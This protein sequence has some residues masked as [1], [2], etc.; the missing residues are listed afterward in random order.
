M[1]KSLFGELTS[2]RESN[3]SRSEDKL[4]H[5]DFAAT[6]LM[7]TKSTEVTPAGRM[8]DR[9][10][11][12]LVV[13][14]SPAQ[15]IR[16]HFASTRADLESASRMITL[17][18][19]SHAWAGWVIK[20]LS[21]AGG[22][23]IERL[24]LREAT[25]LRTLATIERT[26]LVRRHDDSLKIM[27]ADVRAPGRENS[28]IPVALMERSQLTT[29]IM[30]TLG[31]HA[32]DA[33]L[34]SVYEAVTLP[35]W[36]CPNI[37][38]LLPPETDWIVEKMTAMKW[39]PKVRVKHRSETL[40]SAS[41]VWNTVLEHWS[42]VKDWALAASNDP[43]LLGLSDF[44]I[45]VADLQ[46]SPKEAVDSSFSLLQPFD[47]FG[48]IGSPSELIPA[49]DTVSRA[50]G[51]ASSEASH[52]SADVVRIRYALLSMR[53]LEGMLACAV[54]DVTNNKVLAYESPAGIALDMDQAAAHATRLLRSHRQAA[55]GLGLSP[56]INEVTARAG[57]RQV[58]LRPVPR[59][60]RF[61]LLVLLD[62]S[63]A[64]TDA[65]R[66]HLSETEKLL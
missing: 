9:H 47:P 7:E 46:A 48:S 62:R 6:T 11:Q 28:E 5:S 12:E 18:D 44:P 31:S 63:L 58:I 38:F 14:G 34:A 36:R 51:Q 40:L 60:P 13:V 20:A 56:G 59:Q 53:T 23:P 32:V 66:R 55:T 25:T 16:Q 22:L 15:A 54:V 33:L 37:L 49:S 17:L 26:T 52:A 61:F 24:H 43:A 57:T 39:P 45:K 27:F 64:Q 21:D 2:R 3:P 29:I 65:L 4:G 35:T 30:G 41:A 8:V 1:L 50:S 19:P 42:E 10:S